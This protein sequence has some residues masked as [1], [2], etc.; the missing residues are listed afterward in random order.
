MSSGDW[1]EVK[2]LAADFQRAQLSSTAQRLTERNCVEIITKLIELKLL[3]VIFTTDGK[4]Y[5]TPQQLSKEIKDELYMHGGRINLVELARI[6]NVDLNYVTVKAIEIERSDSGISLVLGQLIDRSYT[7]HVADEINDYLSAHGHVTIGDLTRQYDLP[8]DFLQSLV[9]KNLGKTIHAKQDK[10]DQRLFFTEAFVTRNKCIVRGALAAITQPTPVTAILNQCGIQKR[11]F[12]FVVDSLIEAKQVAGVLSGRQSNN[13]LYIPHVYSKAQ[14]EWVTNFYKQNG[15]LEYDALTRLGI[16][17]VHSFIHR[18]LA[19]EKLLMLPSCAVGRQLLDQVEAAVEETLATGSWL[20]IMPLL[21]SVFG[22]EDA[23][24]VLKEVLKRNNSKTAIHKFCNTYI[25]TDIFLQNLSKPFQEELVKKKAEEAVSSGTYQK[26]Q[27]DLKLSKGGGG[28]TNTEVED[29]KVDRREERRRK[30]AGGKAGGGAMGRETKTKSTKKKYQQRN[31]VE[32]S[33]SDEE[34]VGKKS[35]VS[36]KLELIKI[37]EIKRIILREPSFQ[38]EELEPL[39]EEIALYYH[40]ILNKSALTEAQQIFEN[41]VLSDTQSRRKLHS[42]LQDKLN[43]LLN[44]IRLYEK[45]IKQFPNKDTQTQLTKY[46]IKTVATDLVNNL[47]LFV[48]QES[49][50]CNDNVKEI[51]PEMRQKILTELQKEARESLTK[52]NKSLTGNCLEEFMAAVD[53]AFNCMDLVIRKPDKKKDRPQM[54]AHRQALLQQMMDTDDPALTLHLA[55]LI[56]FQNVTQ[57][58]L[59]ASGRFV[60]NILLFLTSHLSQEDYD[61]LQNYHDLVLKLLTVNE[62]D[63][64]L[65]EIKSSLQEKMVTV[66]NI[67]NNS[68]NKT[69]KDEKINGV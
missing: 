66:K 39:I 48:A 65:E 19:S 26:H 11:D 43:M 31:R 29:T 64:Q 44:D 56:I 53:P 55:S 21:P 16:S 18:H 27:L 17:D 1:D 45:G 12:F 62:D 36:S 6:L 69:G 54:L 32:E 42:E 8:T 4:E 23:E 51:T 9:E 47:F 13:C 2:R 46:L 15:Y 30:A 34:V 5:I 25:L 7:Q 49:F 37:E 63:N 52:L 35:A 61:V 59:H 20:D 60:S 33:D 67:A 58:M 28:N 50:T 22:T 41:R 14:N 38:D 10:Q 24:D 68:K 3:D 57:T 40:T